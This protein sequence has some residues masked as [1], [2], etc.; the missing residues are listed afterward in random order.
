MLKGIIETESLKDVKVLDIV[1]IIRSYKEKHPEDE[2]GV[3]TINKVEVSKIKYQEILES[4]SKKMDA[5]W[6][7]LFWDSKKVYIV[8]KDKFFI[9]SNV[10][11]WK[12]S[13]FKNLVNYGVK[14]G[15]RQVYWDQ[16]R[17]SMD[18]W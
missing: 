15:V 1:H 6:Y 17:N 5:G 7:S 8:F 11:P 16:L 2:L 12:P 4:I 18:N 14:Q 3:W 10:N 9:I 13:E